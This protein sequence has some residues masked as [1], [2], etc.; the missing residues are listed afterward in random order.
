MA[1]STFRVLTVLLVGATASVGCNHSNAAK[2]APAKAED[3]TAAAELRA[4]RAEVTT[5]KDGADSRT[6]DAR[7]QEIMRR[8]EFRNARW[9][10]KF[11]APD[12]KQVIYSINQ[13]QLFQPASAMKVFVAGTALSALGPDYRFH[14]PVYRTGPVEH[15]VLKGDLVLVASGDLLLGGRVQPDGTLAVPEQDHTYDMSPDAVPVPGDPLRSIKEMAEQ[16]AARGITRVEGRVLVD[17]SLFRE[18]K[19][20]VGGTGKI[21]VSP[22]VINDNIVDVIV[23]PG[24]REGEP[25]SL[26][27]SPETPYVKV[28]NQTKTTAASEAPATGMVPMRPG[29]LRF[30][31]D[32]TNHDGTHTVALTGNIPLG[33]R[34]VLRAYRVPEPVRFA[35]MVLAEAL[36]AKGIAAEVDLL[37]KPDFQ[38]LSACYTPEHRVAEH[39][40]PPLSEEVK[41][42][43]KLSSN[44]HTAHFPYVV[45]AIAGHDRENAQKTGQEFQRKLF[46]KAGVD[47]AGRKT[48]GDS[49]RDSASDRV[50]L[51]GLAVHYS[52]DAFIRFLTYM[53]EQP[54]F[55]K[56]LRALP[57]MGKDGSLAKVQ[58]NSPAAGH[59]F[60]KTGTAL[61]MMRT[62]AGPADPAK[63]AMRAVK[64]LA[65]YM[66]LPDGRLV[67]FA[68]FLELEDQRGPRGVEPLNQVMGEIASVVYESL[69]SQPK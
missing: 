40:S 41:V 54:Y 11:Y 29:V 51:L 43:L 2:A 60:A 12:T 47:P 58:A 3:A 63:N 20:E 50:G 44:P 66:E 68:E 31:N 52:P 45:G 49:G 62:A 1:S 17:A 39:V 65:G 5:P 67:V 38:A 32:V 9:G 42:M 64:A 8:P 28:I 34:P 24:S 22:M 6:L 57:I 18:E 25:G 7:L 46:E 15:G 19:N 13:D 37:V 27:I 36:R 56:F 61:S 33:S 10:I 16:I 59:V 4:A 53:S 48:S 30:S 14:T 21:T 69:V 23:T 26:R 35:E 55:T